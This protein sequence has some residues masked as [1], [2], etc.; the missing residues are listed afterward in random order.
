MSRM[1]CVGLTGGIGSGK[2]TVTQMFEK[3]GAR[4]IDADVIVR[5]LE[6]VGKPAYQAI[7]QLFGAE[8]VDENQE[9]RRH[10]IR[11]M[12]FSNTEL[13]KRLEAILHPLVRTEIGK[14]ITDNS[15]PYCVISI[16]LLFE[17]NSAYNIDRI[18]VIDV[19]EE[20]QVA[21]AAGR[22]GVDHLEIQNI[23]AT[24]IDRNQRLERADDVI[25][26]DADIASLQAK[27][28][29]L[30]KKY[31]QFADQKQAGA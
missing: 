1:Y 18:L 27:V 10:L 23:I 12:I 6:G 15:H 21:R 2:T 29:Q 11:Q 19:L 3:L 5:E 16:P 7:L 28:C 25:N 9:L 31:L 13:K 14:R 26:N 4:I 20:L 30:H 17:G 22:D 8:V 24:Q